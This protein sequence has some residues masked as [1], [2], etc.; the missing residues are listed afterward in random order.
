MH[1]RFLMIPL[2]LF[3]LLTACSERQL[4]TATTEDTETIRLTAEFSDYQQNRVVVF[5]FNENTPAQEIKEHALTLRYTQD[6]LLAAYY[7]IADSRG[8]APGKLSGAGNIMRAN[9]MM[10][11]DPDMDA[12]HYAYMRPFVG[13]PLF[14]DCVQSPE[15]ILCRK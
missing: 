9:D 2:A 7:F 5:L 4:D 8:I 10:F 1:S 6:R 12:W 15:G 13:E 3:F 14:H 11:D